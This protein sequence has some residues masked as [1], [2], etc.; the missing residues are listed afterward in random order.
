MRYV[1]TDFDCNPFFIGTSLGVE[2]LECS[3]MFWGSVLET[4]AIVF[5]DWRQNQNL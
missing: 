3:P 5:A 4:I 1:I 2:T